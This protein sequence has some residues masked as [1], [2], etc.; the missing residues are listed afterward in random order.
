MR[1]LGMKRSAGRIDSVDHHCMTSEMEAFLPQLDYLVLVLADT[2]ESK[3]FISAKE[4]ALLPPGAVLINV[5]RGSS[6]NQPDLIRA[7]ETGQINGAVLDVFEQEP[8]PEDRPL[9]AMENVMITPHNSAYSFP[10][11]IADICAANYA[12]YLA[13]SPLQYDVDFNRDY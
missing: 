7:L 12:R 2:S 1:V 5:G 10:D 9:Y 6:I 11:Q 4:L 13:G 3:Q 8:L